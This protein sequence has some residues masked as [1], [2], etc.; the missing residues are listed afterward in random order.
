MDG[1][2]L[3][4][5]HRNGSE[6]A[7]FDQNCRYLPGRYPETLVVELPGNL[8]K[9]PCLR[10]N[11]AEEVGR[12]NLVE[13]REQLDAEKSQCLPEGLRRLLPEPGELKIQSH[14]DATKSF[15]EEHP[16]VPKVSVH[17]AL[18][19]SHFPD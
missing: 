18:G 14:P 12:P 19:T 13:H 8:R 5:F 1:G 16:F 10:D 17:R 2:V 7:V 6:G 11:E 15:R 3:R 4:V 9:P